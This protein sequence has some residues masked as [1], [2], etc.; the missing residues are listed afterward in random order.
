M[1]DSQRLVIKLPAII[2]APLRLGAVFGR[3]PYGFY[4]LLRPRKMHC[5][6]ERS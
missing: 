5:G 3:W 6:S 4:T 2:S 1:G